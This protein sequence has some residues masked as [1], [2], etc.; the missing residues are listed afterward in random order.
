QP[1]PER[2]AKRGSRISLARSVDLRIHFEQF[3]A[4]IRPKKTTMKTPKLFTIAVV[5]AGLAFGVAAQAGGKKHEEENIN[6]SDVPA[7]VQ[8]AADKQTKGGKIV[9]W[10]KEGADYEAVIE[11]N[12]KEWGFKFD[13][14]GK[15][16]GKHDESKEKGEKGEKY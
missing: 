5:S 8:Q 6:S 15:M 1:K 13:A 2:L 4:G 7:A 10:E 14:N 12:G 11:K 3:C 9:R 16:L